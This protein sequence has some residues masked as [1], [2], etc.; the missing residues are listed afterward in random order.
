MNIFGKI[1]NNDDNYI[2][3]CNNKIESSDKVYVSI[4]T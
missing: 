1:K 2:N 4:Q 3:Y